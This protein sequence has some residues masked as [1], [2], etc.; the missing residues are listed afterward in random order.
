MPACFA[1]P[2]I[3]YHLVTGYLQDDEAWQEIGGWIEAARVRAVMRE[4]RV[5]MLGHYYGGML[6]VYSDLTKH[7]PSSEIISNCWKCANCTNCASR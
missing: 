7:R 6:D 5:G 1:A 3:D 4:N 2:G